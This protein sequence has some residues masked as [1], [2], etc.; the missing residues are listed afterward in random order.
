MSATM[1]AMANQNS[2]TVGPDVSHHFRYNAVRAL[3]L[4]FCAL[5]NAHLALATG[6]EKNEFPAGKILHRAFSGMIQPS[7]G[8]LV[9][10]YEPTNAPVDIN[11][12]ELDSRLDRFKNSLFFLGFKFRDSVR[13]EY[14]GFLVPNGSA[15]KVDVTWEKLVALDGRDILRGPTNEEAEHDAELNTQSTNA[16][17]YLS[18]DKAEPAYAV[19]EMKLTV[20]VRFAHLTFDCNDA[21]KTKVSADYSVTLQQCANNLVSLNISGDMKDSKPIIIARDKTGGCLKTMESAQMVNDA[22][23]CKSQTY[24]GRVEKVEVFVPL[25]HVDRLVTV[26]ATRTPVIV[27]KGAG[28]IPAFR[29]IA[30]D[31]SLNFSKIDPESLKAQVKILPLRKY[32]YPAYNTPEIAVQ[33]P[34]LD[35]SAFARIEFDEP[36]LSDANG[37]PVECKLEHASFNL[38]N[39]SDRIRFKNGDDSIKT[40]LEF[41]RAAGTVSIRYPADIKLY[42]FT[43]QSPTT[44]DIEVTFEGSK[45]VVKGIE[46]PVPVRQRNDRLAGIT[47]FDA[48]GN[49]LRQWNHGYAQAPDKTIIS[50]SAGFWG[51]VQ[52]DRIIKVEEWL[53]IQLSYDLP[54]APILPQDHR[55]GYKNK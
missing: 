38:E 32:S 18:D 55:M 26:K 22:A 29:Y 43:P 27:G 8:D 36:S 51:Q 41:A 20:P 53:N 17:L 25:K 48:D 7:E 39:Y 52:K 44:G 35:N 2:N 9:S 37:R 47:A 30:D 33:L 1:I 23:I 13:I 6:S 19:G 10:Q 24:H 28:E 34:P 49:R 31:N 40:P 4:L 45:V 11:D 14:D 46:L 42:T 3:A 21:P 12:S 16:A 50:H 15:A 54:P 5:V